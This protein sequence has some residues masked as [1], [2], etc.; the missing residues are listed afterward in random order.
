MDSNLFF[1]LGGFAIVVMVVAVGWLFMRANRVNLTG[2][3]EGEK[4][5]WMRS[6]PPSE[7]LAATQADGEGITLFDEDSGEKLAAPFAEQIEDILQGLMEA[8]PLL[9]KFKVDFGTAPDGGLEVWVDGKSYRE[10]KDIPE[11]PIRAAI[12][13]AI[14]IYNK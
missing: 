4:P 6:T 13:K 7:T 3:Q 9:K 14:E 1:V 10:I 2:T 12:Q 11:E 5:E 8:D